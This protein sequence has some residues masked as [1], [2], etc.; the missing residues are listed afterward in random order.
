MEKTKEERRQELEQKIRQM[1]EES[2]VLLQHEKRIRKEEEDEDM[3]LSRCHDLMAGIGR[4]CSS[5]NRKIFQLLDEK[6]YLLRTFRRKKMEYNEQFHQEVK[7]QR[8][9]LERDREQ[10]QQ[11]MT[12]LKYNEKEE[13]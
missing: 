3:E 4:D 8:Q 1:E 6:E 11:K 7:K 12:D 5:N 9:K 13:R 10:L 2:E